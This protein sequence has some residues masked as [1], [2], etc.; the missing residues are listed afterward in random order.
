MALLFQ[1][2]H[3]CF[4][5]TGNTPLSFPAQP[6]HFDRRK[7]SLHF[8][9]AACHFE[10]SD[11]SAVSSEARNLAVS[12]AVKILSV[13]LLTSN[14]HCQKIS[15]HFVRRNDSAFST[16]A[17]PWVAIVFDVIPKAPISVISSAA[18]NPVVFTELRILFVEKVSLR[19]AVSHKISPHF[20]RRNDRWTSCPLL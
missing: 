17:P 10:R 11:K 18:R 16:P 14:L 2:M 9:C 13:S 15:P 1:P 4:K 8:I 5:A 12:A 20:V 3:P 19:L 7:K 6:C